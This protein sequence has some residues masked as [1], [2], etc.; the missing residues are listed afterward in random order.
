MADHDDVHVG[1]AREAAHDGL[2]VRKRAV[3]VELVEIREDFIDVVERIGARRVTGDE[4]ALPGR[5]GRIDLL[6][7]L[8]F[9]RFEGSDF[10]LNRYAALRLRFGEL[11]QFINLL[12]EHLNVVLEFKEY[13]LGHLLA[14]RAA[15]HGALLMLGQCLC[16]CFRLKGKS[17][18]GFR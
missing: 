12:L 3:A 15:P 18:R 7:E 4:R 13:F 14:C 5:E 10:A 17:R 16:G 1:K 9:L 2:I 6:D 11:A 8:V